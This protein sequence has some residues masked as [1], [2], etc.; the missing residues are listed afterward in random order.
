MRGGEVALALMRKTERTR[1]GNSTV[2]FEV[3]LRHVETHEFGVVSFIFIGHLV[4][5]RSRRG[6]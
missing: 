6:R 5:M 2:L 4:R 1:A 3:F